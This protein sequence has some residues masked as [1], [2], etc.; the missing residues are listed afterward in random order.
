MI[1]LRCRNRSAVLPYGLHYE[2]R[3][4]SVILIFQDLRLERFGVVDRH[5]VSI[6]K[7]VR[8]YAC[9]Y[10]IAFSV[11][12]IHQLIR[13]SV[14][15]AAESYNV[16]FACIR[17]RKPYRDNICLS[18][19]GQ[20]AEHLDSRHVL[21]DHFSQLSLIHRIES[22]NRALFRKMLKSSLLY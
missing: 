16:L 6:L 8:W 19:A 3:Y 12:V 17:A 15:S 13:P 22:R 11:R 18:A 20:C 7:A 2:R 1:F 14:V 21:Y 5:S 4:A 9:L 10:V